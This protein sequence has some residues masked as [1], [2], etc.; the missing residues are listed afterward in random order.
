MTFAHVHDPMRLLGVEAD[1]SPI[2]DLQRLQRRPSPRAWRRQVRLA[3]FSFEPMLG[4][5]RFD[6]GYEVAAI[7]GVVGMLELA[8][9]AFGEVPARR[10]LVVRTEC[11]RPVVQHCI[12]RNAE[13]HVAATSGYPIA[14]R[15]NADDEFVHRRSSASGIAAA[16]SSAIMCGP[17]SSAARPC[18][19][20]A[21][22][23]ASNAGIPRATKEA[24]IP[25]RTSPVPA[26]AS[27]AGAGGAKPSRPSGE[28]TSV[29][30]PL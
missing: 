10:F 27:H 22:E 16:R 24:M 9:A 29:S 12:A 21:A 8:S 5:R 18:T 2:P 19:Q 4:Q 28:A 26:V 25:A 23:A 13:G 17:A 1:D 14:A 7:G 15:S 3:D 30:G 20:T 11:E 6:P